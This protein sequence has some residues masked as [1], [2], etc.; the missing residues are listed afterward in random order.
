MPCINQ[1]T[2][3]LMAVCFFA[4]TFEII[5]LVEKIFYWFLFREADFQLKDIF[6]VPSF[7]KSINF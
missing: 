2:N 5:W 3:I 7:P 4:L 6:Q 1:M